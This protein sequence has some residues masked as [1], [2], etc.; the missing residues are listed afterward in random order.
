MQLWFSGKPTLTS[1]RRYPICY[2]TGR[3]GSP[4]ELFNIEG[5]FPQSS[6]SVSSWV[7][8][9]LYLTFHPYLGAYSCVIASYEFCTACLFP[10]IHHTPCLTCPACPCWKSSELS[11]ATYHL[12]GSS[13]GGLLC[14]WCHGSR[15][16]P[17]F[18]APLACSSCCVHWCINTANI[19]HCTQHLVKHIERSH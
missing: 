14:H 3:S 1:S 11:I 15:T 8:S 19:L 9:L 2:N 17:K 16:E 6:K 10:H 7:A 5:P 4:R 13:Q 12:E 18:L